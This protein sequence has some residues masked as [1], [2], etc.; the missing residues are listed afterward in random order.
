M[1]KYQCR[2]ILFDL[3]GVLVDSRRAVEEVWRIWGRERDRDPEPFIRVAHGRRISET[4]R[5]VDPELD[6]A[7]EAAALD[8]LE[9]RVTTGIIAVPGAPELVASIPPDRWGIVTSGSARIARLRLSL[10]GIPVPPVFVTAEQVKVGKPDPQGYLAGARALGQLPADCLVFEDAPPGV[11]AAKAAGMRVVGILTTQAAS[12]LAAAGACVEDLTH[13]TLQF[14]Q[15]A[16]LV[17]IN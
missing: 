9:E 16:I 6:T 15:G 8:S 7:R 13:V 5:M 3:D 12:A 17:S 4:L 14:H 2:A 11:A 10:A 1:M